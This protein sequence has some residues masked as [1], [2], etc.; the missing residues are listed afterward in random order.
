MRR[1]VNGYNGPVCLK[2]IPVYY[3]WISGDFDLGKP[4]N[5]DDWILKNIENTDNCEA[6]QMMLVDWELYEDGWFVSGDKNCSLFY[7][8]CQI[9]YHKPVALAYIKN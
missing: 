7:Y 3:N 8:L 6:V 5:K 9:V 4:L 2:N 1:A